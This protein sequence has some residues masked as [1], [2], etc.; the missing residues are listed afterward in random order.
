MKQNKSKEPAMESV[1]KLRRNAYMHWTQRVI[2]EQCHPH[3]S[4]FAAYTLLQTQASTN[5]QA[6][7]NSS[8]QKGKEKAKESEY[9]KTQLLIIAST[10]FLS[11]V[12]PRSTHFEIRASVF[13]ILASNTS[14]IPENKMEYRHSMMLLKRSFFIMSK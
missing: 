4:M 6:D 13:D 5:L 7:K 9:D 11:W 3:A 10:L 12:Y 14:N 1:P 8:A 2:N